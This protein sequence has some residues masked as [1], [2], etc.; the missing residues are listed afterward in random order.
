[1][2]DKTYKVRIR[3]GRYAPDIGALLDML[4]YEGARVESWSPAGGA[5]GGW[6]VTLKSG[7]YTPDRWLSFG[8]VPEEVSK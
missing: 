3:G 8:I 6:T 4:R 1:M 7:N 5:D 2:R